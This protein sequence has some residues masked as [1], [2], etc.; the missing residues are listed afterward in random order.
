MLAQKDASNDPLSGSFRSSCGNRDSHCD[1][2]PTNA[3]V[4]D[5][6]GSGRWGLNSLV[7][8]SPTEMAASKHPC[9]STQILRIILRIMANFD[10]SMTYD[11]WKSC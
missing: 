1:S 2:L 4:S 10:I 7:R 11:T 8:I 3:S 5:R 6:P 9:V